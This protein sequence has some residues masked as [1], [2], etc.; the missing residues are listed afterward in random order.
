MDKE[1]INK[2]KEE[3]QTFLSKPWVQNTLIYTAGVATGVGIMLA[4]GALSGAEA[5]ATA[6]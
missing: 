3:T 2:A 4:K 6:S 5:V 1:K